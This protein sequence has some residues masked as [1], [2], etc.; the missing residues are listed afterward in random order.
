MAKVDV[1]HEVLRPAGEEFMGGSEAPW[2]AANV[3]IPICRGAGDGRPGRATEGA[4][5]DKVVEGVG[6]PATR[7]RELVHGDVG[8][9]PDRVVRREGVADGEPEGGRSSVP[10]VLRDAP[11]RVGVFVGGDSRRSKGVVGAIGG[12][13]KG[14]PVGPRWGARGGATLRFPVLGPQGKGPFLSDGLGVCR[15][16]NPIKGRAGGKAASREGLKPR[17]GV[18]DPEPLRW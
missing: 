3:S 7:T 17:R 12:V 15:R 16:L 10:R 6:G 11:A 8:L 13:E 9:E 1:C 18:R 2:D 14:V 4:V 5:K